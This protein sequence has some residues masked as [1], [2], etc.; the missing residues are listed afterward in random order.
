MTSQ[1]TKQQALIAAVTANP[2]HYG[3]SLYV[4]GSPPILGTVDPDE[5]ERLAGEKLDKGLDLTSM[6]PS[7]SWVSVRR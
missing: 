2:F 6:P 7:Y 1:A 3:L 4:S 5:I